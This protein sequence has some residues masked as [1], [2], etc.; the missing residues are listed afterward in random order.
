MTDN[1][2][3]D[4]AEPNE[5]SA[6]VRDAIGCALVE[7]LTTSPD[8]A[9]TI[10][11][12]TEDIAA[13]PYSAEARELFANSP[14]T[15]Q[16]LTAVARLYIA[17]PKAYQKQAEQLTSGTITYMADIGTRILSDYRVIQAALRRRANSV[18]TPGWKLDFSGVELPENDIMPDDATGRYVYLCSLMDAG[19]V[20]KRISRRVA[21]LNE[22]IVM[23]TSR[24]SNAM[25]N[26]ADK[27]YIR[28]KD[29]NGTPHD[30]QTGRKGADMTAQLSLFMDDIDNMTRAEIATKQLSSVQ[31]F[32]LTAVHSIAFDNPYETH[33]YGSDIVKRYGWANPSQ[34]NHKT[35]KD[36]D[37]GKSVRNKANELLDNP[38]EDAA[39]EITKMTMISCSVDVSREASKLYKRGKVVKGIEIRPIIDGRV[40]LIETVDEKGHIKKDFVLKLRPDEGKP[41]TNALPTFEYSKSRGDIR[42]LN[43]GLFNFEQTKQGDKI[44][45]PVYQV[46]TTHRRMI[47]Y[48]MKQVSSKGMS[49]TIMFETMFASLGI[50][51]NKDTRY[52]ASKKLEQMLNNLMARGFIKSWTFKWQGQKRVG[53]TVLP[54][55]NL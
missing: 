6:S 39:R 41:V 33:I 44:I 12:I 2:P 20:T 10:K 13:D 25:F 43:S 16:E 38:L 22:H 4:T 14:A 37:T 36:P 17:A 49:N 15:M 51:L 29:Y 45:K 7:T 35:K 55:Q 42:T 30:L 18:E 11:A 23:M 40:T 34:K 32:W 47:A 27:D 19:K 48:I 5:L 9:K 53:V 54:S 50:D 8:V 26:P 46:N 28:A 31:E 1:A 21:A 52:R 3:I 24:V